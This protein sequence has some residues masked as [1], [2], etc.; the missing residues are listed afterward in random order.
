MV[1]IDGLGFYTIISKRRISPPMIEMANDKEKP[2][3]IRE[4]FI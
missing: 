4:V 2:Y 3:R 1:K